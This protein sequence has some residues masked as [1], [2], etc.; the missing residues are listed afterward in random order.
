M[1]TDSGAAA[2][3]VSKAAV[4]LAAVSGEEMLE[5][6]VKSK[7]TDAAVGSSNPNVSTTAMSFAKGGQAVNLANNA[8]PKA[9]AVAGG[10]ALRALVKSGKLASGAAD[11]SQ[12]SGKEVQG[13]G[14]TAANKLLVAIEDVMKK[15]VKSILEKAKGEIDKVR[16]SQ[17]L[18]SES[19]NKK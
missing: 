14:V 11:S 12:G 7:D 8:T 15:T 3:D 18:T 16:G 2:A 19:G 13:I 10:I 4:I 9:A 5:S 6:I 17:G 1:A